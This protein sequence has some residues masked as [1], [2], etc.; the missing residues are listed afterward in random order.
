M[1]CPLDFQGYSQGETRF[2]KYMQEVQQSR[3]TDCL[4]IIGK[5]HVCQE[6]IY[7]LHGAQ[8]D[9]F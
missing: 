9:S 1:S 5:V 6:H 3:E 8:V 2:D 7:C 4:I